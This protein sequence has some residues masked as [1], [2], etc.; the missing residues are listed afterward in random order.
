MSVT[1]FNSLTPP[2]PRTHVSFQIYIHAWPHPLPLLTFY[3]NCTL[4]FLFFLSLFLSENQKF[5]RI[6]LFFL[7]LLSSIVIISFT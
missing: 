4:S 1:P 5:G 2:N 6:C 3:T 7:S